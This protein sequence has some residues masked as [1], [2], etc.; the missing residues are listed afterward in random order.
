MSSY[1]LVLIISPE[2][3]DEEMSDFITK[4]SELVNK[5]G[6]SVDEV[7]QWGRRKL[8]YPI[9]RSMEG[10]YVLAKVKMKP[11]LTKELEASLRLSGKILRHLL[12][13]SAD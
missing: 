1:E 13:R 4:L 8:A 6:G 5:V 7:N 9:K 10:N 11:A 12:I 3:I 2:V